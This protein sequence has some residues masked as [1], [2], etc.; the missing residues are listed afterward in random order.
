MNIDATHIPWAQLP[1][2]ARFGF[3]LFFSGIFGPEEL[4]GK[5]VAVE[6]AKIW[7][8]EQLT[9]AFLNDDEGFWHLYRKYR[10]KYSEGVSRVDG[11]GFSREEA[12][13]AGFIKPRGQTII[14]HLCPARRRSA[15][16]RNGE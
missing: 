9:L 7:D 3:I 16:P 14:A 12:E 15:V 1:L 11:Y 10:D 5:A 8:S 4:D 2:E 13:R 6:L